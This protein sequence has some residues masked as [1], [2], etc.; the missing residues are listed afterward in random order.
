MNVISCPRDGILAWALEGCLLWQ[1]SGLCPPKSVQD[2][3]SEYFEGEDAMGRWIEERCVLATNAKALTAELF[4]DW[5][6]WAESAG[7]FVGSQRRFADLLITRGLEKWR[8]S[9]GLRG[10]RGIG[11]KVSP[12]VPQ[13]YSDL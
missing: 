8:N 9:V 3:T 13:H 2:A 6:Q 7:E 1:R 12:P 5:K 11:L 10:F 4:N